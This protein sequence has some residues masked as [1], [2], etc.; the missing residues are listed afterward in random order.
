MSQSYLLRRKH[1]IK[2]ERMERDHDLVPHDFNPIV[3]FIPRLENLESGYSRSML[4][5]HVWLIFKYEWVTDAI[6]E[7]SEIPPKI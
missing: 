4:L 2:R 3:M 5:P 6:K 7:V 1:G